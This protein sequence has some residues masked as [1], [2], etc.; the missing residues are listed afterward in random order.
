MSQF[1]S[2]PINE[3]KQ[4]D[5]YWTAREITQQPDVWRKVQEDIENRRAEISNWL[6]PIL[7]IPS[8]RIVLTG[9]GTSAY[10]GES[11]A[12]FLTLQSGR[13]FETI[14]TTDLVAS[15]KEY[16][17]TSIPTLLI[18]YG[19]SG[20]SPES[21]AAI[22]VANEILDNC[23]H[24]TITCNDNGSLAAIT[25]RSE[26]GFNVLMPAETLDNSFAMTSSFTSMIVATLTVFAPNLQQLLISS[27]I[28][29]KIIQTQVN[30][31]AELAESNGAKTVFLGSG[32]LSGTAKE[33]ALKLLELTA[34]KLDCYSESS[35]GFRHGPKSLVNHETEVF[36]LDSNDSHTSKYDL[37]LFNE[38]KDDNIAK[39]V[40]CLSSEIE[41]AELELQGPWLGLAYIVYC[42]IYAFYKSIH[43]GITPDNPCPTGE[44][45]RVVQG[46]NIYSI[47]SNKV[48]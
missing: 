40:V 7:S 42:Q 37:D 30:R 20:D 31:I 15:P 38:L 14:S 10:I 17:I 19:R 1:L 44:V 21:V 5:A 9:A 13:V 43:L 26:N 3:L 48:A 16:L 22:N 24:L 34:G 27:K 18:S 4:L 29:T 45:N 33:A 41:L 11:I 25:A 47:S 8:L 12:P 39:K 35:L 36:I 46:V 32:S 28:S 2:L 6:N 23:F